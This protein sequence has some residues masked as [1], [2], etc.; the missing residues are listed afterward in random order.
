[1][2]KI[3]VMTSGKGGV[4]KTTSAASF[5]AGLALKGQKT[6]VVDFD[7]NAQR[8]VVVRITGTRHNS[9]QIIA[10]RGRSLRLDEAQ[11]HTDWSRRRP[12]KR[13]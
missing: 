9:R 8:P 12:A 4:G 7:V 1:M 11:S 2:S 10:V 3:I 13:R 5:A 6:V